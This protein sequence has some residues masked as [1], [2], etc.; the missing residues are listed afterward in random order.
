MTTHVGSLPPA[1][2]GAAHTAGSG[3]PIWKGKGTPKC[4]TEM[5]RSLASLDFHSFFEQS[6]SF[7]QCLSNTYHVPGLGPAQEHVGLPGCQARGQPGP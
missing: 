1:L 5:C 3:F 6:H 7:S 4:Q 2:P